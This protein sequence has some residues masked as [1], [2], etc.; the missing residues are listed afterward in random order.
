MALADPTRREILE[1]LHDLGPLNAGAIADSFR[2]VTRPAI[3]RHLRVL[4]ECGLVTSESQGRE[5]RYELDTA[6]LAAAD[7]W[8][9]AFT[10]GHARSLRALRRK[11]E[12][13]P[14]SR[15]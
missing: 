6:P 13:G 12:A 5:N 10:A 3:S 1:L 7:G 9:A 8:L 4:R 14:R 15:D 11:A 2:A